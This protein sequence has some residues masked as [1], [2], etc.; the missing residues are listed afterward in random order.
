MSSTVAGVY[1]LLI[2]P[3]IGVSACLWGLTYNS[4]VSPS[5]LQPLLRWDKATPVKVPYPSPL[6]LVWRD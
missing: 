2:F 3:R 1:S 5:W 4:A 6:R